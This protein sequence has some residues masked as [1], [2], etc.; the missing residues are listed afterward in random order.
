MQ[1]EQNFIVIDTEGK[2]VL[3]EIAV[4]N[5]QGKITYEAFAQEDPKSDEINLN[6]K[7]LRE[8]ITDFY[9]LAQGNIVVGHHIEH[10]KEVLQRSFN[11]VSFKSPRSFFQL[12]CTWTLAKQCLPDL[13]SYSLE[14]LSKHLNLKVE[15]KSFNSNLAHTARYDAAFTYHLYQKIMTIQLQQ[16]LEKQLK[17][18]SNPFGSSRVDTPFQKHLD[19]PEIYQ[20]Q[21]ATL[22]SIITDIKHDHNHQSKGAVVIGEPGT[23]KTHLMM[24]LAK[25]LLNSN[26]LLFIRQPNNPDSVLYH[27]YSRILE[28]LIEKVPGSKYTQLEYLLANSFSKLMK[29]YQFTA[30]NKTDQEIVNTIT[31][32]NLDIYEKLGAEDTR[33]KRDY[34]E[35]I[36]KRVNEWWINEYGTA[37][38]GT[39]ILKGIIKFCSY[40][41]RNRKELV[42]RWLSAEELTIEELEKVDLDNWNES[43]SKEDFSLQAISVL[44]K[45]S[46]LD[47]P[48][49]IVFDQLEGLGLRHNR[50]TL[51]SF[52][53]AI[54]EIFTHVTN[55][56][57]IL[58]L[59]P[60][61]WEQFKDIFDGS[62]VDRVS[63][64]KVF[65]ELPSQEE[66]KVILELNA[67]RNGVSLEQLFSTTDLGDIL[68]H[69]S[70]RAVLNRAADYYR[71]KF[72][73]I[74]LPKA[75]KE[76]VKL[77]NQST[78][79]TEQ[80]LQ[81]LEQL[82]QQTSTSETQSTQATE[83]R[84]QH[85]EQEVKEIRC[86]MSNINQA[87]QKLEK[88]YQ[89]KEEDQQENELDDYDESIAT[90][91]ELV[92]IPENQENGSQF[93]S[94]TTTEN[95]VIKYLEKQRH[96]LLEKYQK[97]QIISDSDDLGKLIAITEEFNVLNNLE[98]DHLRLGKRK[99]PEH[100][101]IIKN[102]QKF[103]LG[104]LQTDGGAFTSRI[105]NFNEL[106][107]L[108]KNVHFSLF[109]DERKPAITG[110]VG[111]EEI[112]KLN[113]AN[114]G[115]FIILDKDNRI[116]FE[117]IY[118]LVVDIQNR[119]LEIDIEDALAA[120]SSYFKDYWLI[121]ILGVN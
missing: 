45:L 20:E 92:E 80:R 49:I 47:E 74:P 29:Q 10:D 9:H 101:M 19:A 54:K 11:E 120:L 98:I 44:S 21:F 42:T 72:S 8:I 2:Y 17:N 41:D 43:M 105:K 12:K 116:N 23:G 78:Q 50:K 64:Y 107:V 14:Y 70:V 71:Y 33:K 96:F 113:N 36:G 7:P 109:R 22:K 38:Y 63:Q 26:R 87:L 18:Q 95:Q 55:S 77:D 4:I 32:S 5:S 34:W 59:F 76:T 46:V 104:F 1:S 6:V 3:R 35:H 100:L 90:N 62:I 66:L 84:L 52:G 25:E 106:V 27:T 108:N 67:Q 114:N 28:S 82:I 30:T 57:V 24:R 115:E 75:T 117:L 51:L 56:L 91:I 68:Q 31:N 40:S 102:K 119:D 81:H 89:S 13:P 94:E 121:K 88:Y 39:K 61:R 60:E 65:L 79:I 15:G 110:K 37:G 118:Q 93:Y 99:V 69:K 73:H 97:L 58:N 83:A 48:L 111:K 53:E 112:E 103:A 85:L 86:M 16:K